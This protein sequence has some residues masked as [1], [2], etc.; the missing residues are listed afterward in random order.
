MRTLYLRARGDHRPGA[1]QRP[2]PRP[3]PEGKPWAQAAASA[4]VLAAPVFA[5]PVPDAVTAYATARDAELPGVTI[6]R[7]PGAGVFAA[8]PWFRPIT[9]RPSLPTLRRVLGVRERL[10]EDDRVP[11]VSDAQTDRLADAL[12]DPAVIADRVAELDAEAAAYDAGHPDETAEADYESGPWTLTGPD[13]EDGDDPA[14]D[15]AEAPAG[16]PVDDEETPQG[17][18]VNVPAPTDEPLP[19]DADA[20]AAMARFEMAH[21]EEAEREGTL[22]GTE[23]M[24]IPDA[25]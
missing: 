9:P 16:D 17:D 23:I 15:S 1:P 21:D 11:E 6:E 3:R 12:D 8:D 4:P 20:E 10:P 5:E 18:D 19:L 13:E 7:T 22:H 14:L 2:D 25:S 24:P